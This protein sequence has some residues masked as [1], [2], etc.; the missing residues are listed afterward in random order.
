MLYFLRAQLAQYMWQTGVYVWLQPPQKTILSPIASNSI[1][2][3]MTFKNVCFLVRRFDLQSRHWSILGRRQHGTDMLDGFCN[4]KDMWSLGLSQ[5]QTIEF[6]TWKVANSLCE[7]LPQHS[8]IARCCTQLETWGICRTMLTGSLTRLIQIAGI[9]T[10]GMSH[11]SQLSRTKYINVGNAGNEIQDCAF[12][13]RIGFA[14]VSL[15]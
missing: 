10:V 2:C 13:L 15:A 8:E 14:T 6:I 1:M 5:Y 4:D 7:H 11:R 3:G 9:P 12:P